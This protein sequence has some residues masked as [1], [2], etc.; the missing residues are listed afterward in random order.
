M[1]HFK[2]LYEEK[3]FFFSLVML[4]VM[5]NISANFPNSYLYRTTVST[6]PTGAGTV[7]V[8]YSDATSTSSS[9]NN[10]DATVRSYNNTTSVTLNATPA[11]GYR[12]LR[13]EASD[14][15]VIS[16]TSTSPTTT[17]TYQTNGASSDYH[18]GFLGIGAYTEYTTRRSFSFTAYFATKGVVDAVVYGGQESIGSAVVVEENIEPGMEVTLVATTI[19]G[20]ELTGWAFDYWEL[21]GEIVS[22]ESTIKVMVPMDETELIYVAHFAKADTENYCFI[23]N[24]ATGRYLRLSDTKSYTAPSQ[25]NPV[26]SFNGSFTLV[27]ESKAISDPGCV[28][29]LV[30]QSNNGGVK[31]ASLISQSVPVGYQTGSKIIT[32]AINV[33][34]VNEGTYSIST[35]YSQGGNDYTLYFRDNNGTPDMTNTTSSASE[36]EILVLNSSTMGYQYFGAAPNP[37]MTRYNKYYTT[38]YTTFPYQLQNGKA[39]YIDHES[40][41]INDAGETKV[42]CREIEDGIVPANFPVILRFDGTDPSGNK[43]LPLPLN[44]DVP[45]YTNVLR[46]HIDVVDGVKVGDGMMYVLSV[47]STQI[48][49]FYKLKS[50]TKMPDNKAYAEVNE[51]L[52]NNAKNVSFIFGDDEI[53]GVDLLDM[54]VLPENYAGEVVFDLQGRR[55][56]NPTKGIYLVNGKKIIIK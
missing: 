6:S 53:D 37:I 46:G 41:V 43:L 1:K 14:G 34:P 56:Q 54:T 7:Y 48:L 26:A 21:N 3:R 22:E 50:G 42:T 23:R 11:D 55:V 38:L 36:W 12:F 27:E 29:I 24:K 51:E 17:L 44:T 9:G 16:S 4:M 30:G 10:Y 31:N 49:G 20:S 25:S 33:R 28:F 39:F 35:I 18:R 47:G 19:N 15:T 2:K 45:S 8:S 32:K 52:Q 40:I 5:Q 13:W